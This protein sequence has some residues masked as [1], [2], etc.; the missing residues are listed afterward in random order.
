MWGLV[1]VQQVNWLSSLTVG[2]YGN[3]VVYRL[4][5][6]AYCKCKRAIGR[7]DLL[8]VAIAI[9]WCTVCTEGLTVSTTMQQVEHTDCWNL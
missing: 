7:T 1:L 3:C 8:L 2:Y 5:F 9:L 4:Y 6:G